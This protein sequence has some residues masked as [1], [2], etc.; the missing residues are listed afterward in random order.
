MS[1]TNF[2]RVK[3]QIK[4]I[5]KNTI[6]LDKDFKYLVSIISTNEEIKGCISKLVTYTMNQYE[7]PYQA[8]DYKTVCT[9]KRVIIFKT[10]LFSNKLV[11]IPVKNIISIQN[12]VGLIFGNI[13]I[14]CFIIRNRQRK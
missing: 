12:K 1:A 13:E 6:F 14:F 8:S 2:E 9:D 11:D 7:H 10:G 5:Y 4:K 3:S